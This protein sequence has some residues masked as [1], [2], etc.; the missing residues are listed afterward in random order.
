M[1]VWSHVSPENWIRQQ[2]PSVQPA[3][4]LQQLL[5]RCIS[6]RCG[7]ISGGFAQRVLAHSIKIAN[8]VNV[9]ESRGR[10]G[11]RCCRYRGEAADGAFETL[12]IIQ[13]HFTGEQREILQAAPL[14]CTHTHREKAHRHT[15]TRRG[16]VNYA[17]GV[18]SK[19]PLFSLQ[20][21]SSSWGAQ[22][23][24]NLLI[25]WLE[26]RSARWLLLSV[27]AQWRRSA[28][29]HIYLWISQQ[30]CFCSVMTQQ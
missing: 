23:I 3:A 6:L 25:V 27:S 11:G 14:H 9:R 7:N 8:I 26:A 19:L 12:Q 16:G 30:A 1:L 18:S 15:H 20:I 28:V 17:K 24:I 29:K 13:H 10:R 5:R 2:V 22:I 21:N 4:V